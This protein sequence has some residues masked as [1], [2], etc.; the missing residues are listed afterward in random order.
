MRWGK[1][2]QAGQLRVKGKEEAIWKNKNSRL[3][4]HGHCFDCLGGQP[5][6]RPPRYPAT[7]PAKGRSPDYW[8]A[9]D[10][11][12]GPTTAAEQH[13]PA[14][15]LHALVKGTRKEKEKNCC[16]GGAIGPRSVLQSDPTI[17]L[18][19]PLYSIGYQSSKGGLVTGGAPPAACMNSWPAAPQKN[20][21]LP[22]VS[23]LLG[24]VLV[25]R[26]SWPV[27]CEPFLERRICLCD[28]SCFVQSQPP[29]DSK[30]A[31]IHITRRCQRLPVCHVKF[32]LL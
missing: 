8:L 26:P 19:H 7:R 5:R 28:S 22:G 3:N 12:P 11:A 15:D 30:N 14:G 1:I 21:S 13:P 6:V 25:S 4:L 10:T 16:A 27:R 32:F 2:L 20:W 23:N 31:S 29:Q 24:G 17:V 18:D 9:S